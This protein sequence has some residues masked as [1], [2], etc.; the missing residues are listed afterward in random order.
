MSI[1]PLITPSL[2]PDNIKHLQG[3]DEETASY[4]H[5]AAQAL[6]EAY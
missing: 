6:S 5:I 2:H 3:Y 1:Y 4:V